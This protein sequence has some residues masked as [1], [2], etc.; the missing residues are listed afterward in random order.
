MFSF[1][2]KNNKFFITILNFGGIQK[3]RLL[4]VAY[5]PPQIYDSLYS[6]IQFIVDF[7]LGVFLKKVSQ[8][9]YLALLAIVCSLLKIRLLYFVK[10][11]I[12]VIIIC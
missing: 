1:K 2:K 9:L 4:K 8:K 7:V 10:A 11:Y 6:T 3:L 5:S 12:V